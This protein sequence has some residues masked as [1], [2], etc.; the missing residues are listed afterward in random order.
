M[1]YSKQTDE[2]WQKKW[3]EEG[4]YQFD[5][6]K[7]GKK[8]YTME[9]FSYPSGANLHLGHWFNFAPA[10]S[11]ARFKTMKGYNVF[12]PMGFDAFGLPAENYAIKTG[13]HPQDST[14]K[15]IE[16]MKRQLEE[17]GGTYDWNYSVETCMPDYYK[18]TQ[19][20]FTKL[21]EAGLAYKKEAPVNWCNS[22]NTV[23][24]NEQVIDCK[25]ERCGNP[26]ERKKLKQ[27]FFKTTEYAN[28][29]LE[30]LE[31]LDWPESTKKVQA[32]WI[33]KSEG[34]KITFAGEERD[35]SLDVF[36]TRPDTIHGVSYV[37]V[38]PE[39]DIVNQ[40]TTEEQKE[41]VEA[42]KEKTA[43]VSDI[44]RMSTQREK[45]GVFTGAYVTNPINGEKVPVWI[46]DYVIEDYGTGAV[47]AVPAHDERDYEFA[48]KYNLPIKQVIEGEKE[49]ALPYTGEGRLI[50][51]GKFNGMD[52]QEAREKITQALEKEE[53]GEKTEN[54]RLKDWLVSRQ[55]YW[56]APIPIINC[57]KCGPVVVPEKD[58]P[59]LL[60]Y[61]VEFK[62]DGES[63]LK[64]SKEFMEC[65]CP[66]CGGPATR[67][68]DTLD[69]FV[70]SSWYY[71]RYPD[72]QNSQK[73]FD[74]EIIN[75]MLPVDVYVG[76]KEHAAMHL[77]YARFMTKALRDLGYLD[78]DEPFKKLVHQG[79]ILG[80]DGN[81][82][83]KS[84]GNTVSPD[85]YVDEFGSDVFR[86]YLMF[87]FEYT[88]GGPWKEEGIKAISRYLSRADNL[89]NRVMEKQ[90]QYQ[91]KED[92][93]EAER[94]L[95]LAKNKTI[96]SMEEDIER[97]QF[98]TAIA[99][100]MEYMNQISK[101]EQTQGEINKEVLMDSVETYMKLLAPLAPH[102]TEEQWE[103][104]GKEES[105][106]K[107][108]WPEYN[109]Q[110]LQ[111]T[112]KEI[113][114]QINGKIRTRAV[115]DT[116]LSEQEIMGII[117]QIPAIA[118]LISE[119]EVKKEFYVPGRIYSLVLGKR[120]VEVDKPETP[121]KA[122]VPVSSQTDDRDEI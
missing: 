76:G 95:L 2:K 86:L 40:I 88:K 26:V 85:Q 9:M 1:S 29:L 12:H 25:C 64:K 52:S 70:C 34:T 101:Y 55:R 48:K 57:E 22:C 20:I 50:N 62:P 122:T 11:F 87:G 41:V 13:I 51:S 15:N 69:T 112:I 38:A 30:D 80:P 114:V 106:H 121:K 10:D 77:I 58:L 37:V 45:T 44:D 21:Y 59:V 93:G 116:S 117:R 56:G 33:G 65:T 3:K 6:N 53:K 104:L 17:M 97:F 39:S 103:K 32:N 19:W 23:L 27:W 31:K 94:E 8:F 108:G 68:A 4:L 79:M 82:M 47:M 63:P 83:S 78:F 35:F 66:E 54:F 73:A 96:K 67:E 107:E 28:E 100:S 18:W 14:I 102:F 71:L 119:Y 16:T 72:A 24:A 120:K 111:S 113:P 7:P 81:K 84:K 109:E 61:D 43:K 75:N 36:T 46:S 98:N 91:E 89:V 99:R 90:D 60:P 74:K 105:I 92:I 49:K 118:D 110:E 115:V 42:Y 5:P